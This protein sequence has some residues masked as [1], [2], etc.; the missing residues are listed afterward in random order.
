MDRIKLRHPGES[1][2]HDSQRQHSTHSVIP[3]KVTDIYRSKST[4]HIPSSRR[5]PG[6]P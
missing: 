4:P 5:K 2:G 1:D 3:A 6:T